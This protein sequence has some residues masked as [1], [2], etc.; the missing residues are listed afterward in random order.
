[1][2]GLKEELKATKQ[3]SDD[4]I[5][6]YR[7]STLKANMEKHF[8]G[9]IK[10]ADQRRKNASQIV[11]SNNI[12]LA[13]IINTAA[14]YKRALHETDFTLVSDEFKSNDSLRNL[15]YAAADIRSEIERCNGIDIFPL[16][17][18]YISQEKAESV[19]PR[20][21]T[22]F[23]YWL[24][25]KSDN[26]E[27]SQK[28]HK[29]TKIVSVAQDIVN[30]STNGRK[31]M[32]KCVGLAIALKTKLN[33][34]EFVEI[35]NR[36]GHFISYDTVLRI[37]KSRVD[38]IQAKDE[39]YTMIPTNIVYNQFTQAVADNSD[40]GQEF[41]SQHMTNTILVQHNHRFD[42]E[43]IDKITEIKK[44]RRR[45]AKFKSIPLLEIRFNKTPKTPSYFK[46]VD[47]H[48]VLPSVKSFAREI[49]QCI[50][51]SWNLSRCMATKLFALE[52][53]NSQPVPGWTGFH[54]LIS[55]KINEPT[56]LG[57]CRSVPAP[58][59]DVNV[60]LTMMVNV[61]KMLTKTDQRNPVLTVDESIYE[62]AKKIQFQVSPQLDHMVIRLGG[63]H[64]AKNFIGVIG[65]RMEESGFGE[66]L[67]D[68]GLFGETQIKGKV[69]V[70]RHAL[71][72]SSHS[73]SP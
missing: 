44:V 50:D 7:S 30:I 54:A 62:I 71:L 63:F 4:E 2:G 8:Q 37:E 18:R 70:S 5:N 73:L 11:Y 16:K 14:E 57:Y 65:R 19:L 47:L 12:E 15:F 3:L 48:S 72:P 51:T 1:M 49:M 34:K 60:V 59:T 9:S 25:E 53:A 22:L 31:M 13:D 66:I 20:K 64:R 38:E 32:P 40:Y 55:S 33:S 29:Y 24:C 58:P 26:I 6:N 69:R 39:G 45:S 10:F 36:N 27:V 35:C 46:S 67:E 56:V 68:S 28:S 52:N 17:P 41:S 61:E 21:L 23:L 43:L 42:D